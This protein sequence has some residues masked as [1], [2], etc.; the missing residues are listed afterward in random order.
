MD[1]H[2]ATELAYKNGYVAGYKDAKS[3]I[4]CCKNRKYSRERN[5][6][7]RKY[8]CEGVLIC[9]NADATDE[10][11]NPVWHHHWCSYGECKE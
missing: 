11:W 10:C 6:A 1:K 8:L 4:V 5:E 9:F 7:E 3:E 2:T